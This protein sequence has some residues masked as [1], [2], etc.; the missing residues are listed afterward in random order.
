MSEP[1]PKRKPRAKPASRTKAQDTTGDEPLQRWSQGTGEEPD[2]RDQTEGSDTDTPNDAQPVQCAK[3]HGERTEESQDSSTTPRANDKPDPSTAARHTPLATDDGQ[4]DR[5]GGVTLRSA[6]TGAVDAAA[7]LACEESR[8]KASNRWILEGRRWETDNYRR[9]IIR[10]CRAAGMTK[11]DASDRAWAACLAAFPPP[12]V[13]PQ[14][15][16]DLTPEPEMSTIVDKSPVSAAPATSDQGVLGLGELPDDWGELPANASLQAEISW[17]TANRLRV[18]DGSGVD[19][20]RALGPAPSYSALSWL[21]TSILFPAKF[22]D[23]SVK[24]TAN[25]E[26]EKEH[27][28]REKLAI[29]EVRAILAEMLDG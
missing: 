11:A 25:Q 10:Q 15:A 26:D 4:A 5:Q 28:R 17:V 12:G 16:E 3:A 1:K 14:V 23:I 9:D 7:S 24:A 22:A 2:T 19:L 27:I 20:S 13:E 6:A 18:R 21:E 8:A 29:E